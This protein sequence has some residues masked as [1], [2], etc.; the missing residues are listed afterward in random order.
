MLLLPD[1]GV[2]ARQQFL[3]LLNSPRETWIVAYSFTMA[4]FTQEIIAA[5]QAGVPIHIYLDNSQSGG[6][7]EKPQVQALVAAGVEVTIGTSTAG[8]A[9]ICHDKAVTTTDG[10]CFVGSCNFSV[11]GWKQVNAIFQFTDAQYHQ[12]LRDQF[13]TLVAY[14]WANNGR[15]R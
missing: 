4:D 13:N 15:I 6:T 10:R 5:H 9:Y 14:A 7:M 12:H 11:T 8:S 3:D 1:D 2:E